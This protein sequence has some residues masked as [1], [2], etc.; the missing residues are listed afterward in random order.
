MARLLIVIILLLFTYPFINCD[1]PD[2]VINERNYHDETLNFCTCYSFLKSLLKKIFF[3]DPFFLWLALGMTYVAG[4]ASFRDGSLRLF[5]VR[6]EINSTHLRQKIIYANGTESDLSLDHWGLPL[7][8]LF[9]FLCKSTATSFL[10][11]SL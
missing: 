9:F 2:L 3:S 4:C 5:I 10:I 11:S 6:R 8:P 1:I 7:V